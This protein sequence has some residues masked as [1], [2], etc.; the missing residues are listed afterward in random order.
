MWRPT[1]DA[2]ITGWPSLFIIPSFTTAPSNFPVG[3]L[4]MSTSNQTAGPSHDFT[5]IFEIAKSEYQ[6]V[7]GKSLDT[8]TFAAKL[9]GCDSPEA[10][11]NVLQMQA[12]A[13]SEFCKGDEKLMKWLRPIVHVLFT[14][15]GTIGEGVGIVS[16]RFRPVRSFSDVRLSGTFTCQ[17]DRHR[18]RYS[19]RGAS[20]P[21]VPCRTYILHSTRQAVRDVVADNDKLIRLF[22][23]IHFFLQR[24]NKYT[25]MP[26]ANEWSELLGKIMAQILFILALSTKAMT[27]GRLSELTSVQSSLADHVLEIFFKKLVGKTN[28]EDAFLRL[29]SLTKE[30]SLMT[31]AKNL[32]VTF[33][34]DGNVKKI[35]G[36]AEDINNKVQ[37]IE[38]ATESIDQNVKAAHERTQCFPSIFSMYRPI[39][40]RIS[41]RSREGSTF[42][43]P[44]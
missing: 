43:T 41:C 40:H 32:E 9:V 31:V 10:F 23:R 16:H 22:E 37:V 28:V 20:P 18:Y 2:V 35:Q 1:I 29:E 4:P 42:V 34:V 21:C 44:W 11:S 39:S 26:L 19:S 14:F 17:N 38:G 13:F 5:T 25:K 33:D 36:L 24:L 12:K 3:S 7:T 15:S 8:H 27:E 6:K 30:E